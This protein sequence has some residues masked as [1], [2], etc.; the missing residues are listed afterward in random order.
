MPAP[1]IVE[2]LWIA[3]EEDTERVPVSDPRSA[4]ISIDPQRMSGTPFFAHTRVPLQALWD[5]VTEGPGMEEFL[6]GFPSVTREQ[7]V[8]TLEMALARLLEGLPTDENTAG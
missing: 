8:R 6:E 5:H 4:L 1:A 7:A 3:E 2:P